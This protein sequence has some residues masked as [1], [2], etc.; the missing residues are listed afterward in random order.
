[1]QT[2]KF[3]LIFKESFFTKPSSELIE[4]VFYTNIGIL[5]RFQYGPGRAASDLEDAATFTA[6]KMY[7]LLLT[8][9]GRN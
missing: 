6:G 8:N 9:F 2:I 1:M 3:I 4:L 7:L 5:F